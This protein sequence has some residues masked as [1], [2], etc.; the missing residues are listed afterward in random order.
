MRRNSGVRELTLTVPY[1]LGEDTRRHLRLWAAVLLANINDYKQEQHAYKR[2]GRPGPAMRWIA[3]TSARP[4]TF[5]WVCCLFQLDPDFARRKIK[6]S[7][8]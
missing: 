4:A 3:D 8:L 2:T 6:E 5:E 1:G 7:M